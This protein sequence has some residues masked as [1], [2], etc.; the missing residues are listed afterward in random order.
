MEADG[1]AASATCWSQHTGSLLVSSINCGR[2]NLLVNTWHKEAG[3][4]NVENKRWW[5]WQRAWEGSFD[6]NER[7]KMTEAI[8]LQLRRTSHKGRKTVERSAK[9]AKEERKPKISN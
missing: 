3:L 7:K 6:K 9:E 8:G 5:G 2:W 4:A 1:E